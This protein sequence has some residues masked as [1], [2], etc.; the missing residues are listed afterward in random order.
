MRILFSF[1]IIFS[2]F[3]VFAQKAP[4]KYISATLEQQTNAWNKGDLAAF[5]EPYWHN[6]SLRFIGKSGITYGWQQTL[7]NYKKNY[8]TPE[9]M[10]TL[11]FTIIKLEKLSGQYYSVIGKWHLARTIG[12]LQGY[13]TLLWKK[14]NGK[15]VIVQ[16]HSS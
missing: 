2:C 7:D 3:G 1:L 11:D 10:G 5:M 13:F 9:A 8:P 15:W 16:D 6:D 12:D 14:I 4:E